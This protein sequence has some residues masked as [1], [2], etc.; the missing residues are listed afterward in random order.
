MG[1]AVSLE[2]VKRFSAQIWT[3]KRRQTDST[4]DSRELAPQ[5]ERM[6]EEGRLS[7]RSPGASTSART[8]PSLS[9][10]YNLFPIL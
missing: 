3:S 5:G 1:V 10:A 8:Y 6:P 7:R 2:C 9:P 4:R